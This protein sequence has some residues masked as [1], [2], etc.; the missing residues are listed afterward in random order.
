MRRDYAIDHVIPYAV[1]G[2]NDLWNLLPTLPQVNLAK[3]DAL[4]ARP[5]LIKRKDVIIGYLS[6]SLSPTPLDAQ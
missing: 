5:L 4:P 6:L 2:N 1:W 3:S